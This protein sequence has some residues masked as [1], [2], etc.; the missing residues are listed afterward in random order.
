M[1]SGGPIVTGVTAT[2]ATLSVASA[3]VVLV[4][5]G[6]SSARKLSAAV[7]LFAVIVAVTLMLAHTTVRKIRSGVTPGSA[8]ARFAL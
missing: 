6:A 7:W 3:T 8:A 1:T 5:S 2:S 4:R